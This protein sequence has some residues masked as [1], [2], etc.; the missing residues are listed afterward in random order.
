[1]AELVKWPVG[2]QNR[3]EPALPKVLVPGPRRL[4]L[5]EVANDLPIVETG[6]ADVELRASDG[7]N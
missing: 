4:Q 2:G 3:L 7:L 6:V 1:M 5:V